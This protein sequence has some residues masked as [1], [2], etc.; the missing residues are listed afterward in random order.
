MIFFLTLF[1][2]ILITNVTARGLASAMV[3]LAMITVTVLLAYFG[4]WDR[5]LG[6]FANLHIHL[7]Y[8]GT[9][10]SRRS[11]CLPG[12]SPCSSSTR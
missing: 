3:V 11:C 7:N 9:S 12:S 10:G 5:I 4:L 6:W 8:G 1:C 2:V